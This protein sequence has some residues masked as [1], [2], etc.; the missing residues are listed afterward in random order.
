M[1]N[2]FP[3]VLRRSHC[4]GGLRGVTSSAV[5]GSG[6]YT[7]PPNADDSPLGQYGLAATHRFVFQGTGSNNFAAYRNPDNGASRGWGVMLPIGI[8]LNNPAYSADS[9]PVMTGFPPTLYINESMP[10]DFGI[11]SNYVG[12]TMAVLD[13]FTVTAG[14]E[15]WEILSVAN[16]SGSN[17]ASPMFMAR[18]TG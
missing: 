15:V 14:T 13:T 10:A 3:T 2:Q 17:G 5:Y 4:G 12:N 18:T 9:S 1:F 16:S 8:N 6:L 7:Y 11:A